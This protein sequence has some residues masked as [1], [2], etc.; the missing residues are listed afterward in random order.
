M[1]S[2]V[3][4]VEGEERSEVGPSEKAGFDRRSKRRITSVVEGRLTVT[5]IDYIVQK[6]NGASPIS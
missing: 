4:V 1:H 2:E 3:E 6:G 5:I